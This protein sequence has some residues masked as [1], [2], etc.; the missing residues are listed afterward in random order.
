MIRW[1]QNIYMA[2]V[3]V[4]KTL[5]VGMRYWI[6]TYDPKRRTFTEQYEYPELPAAITPRFR[7]FHRYDLTSCIACERCSRD[8]PANCIYIGKEKA[9][10]KKRIPGDE[11]HDRLYEVHVVRIM[12]RIVSGRLRFHGFDL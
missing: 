9:V 8:C 12:H 3:T 11:L 7:G 4:L 2:V 10:G 6:I 1:F 5:W